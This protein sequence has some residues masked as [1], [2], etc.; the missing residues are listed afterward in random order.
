M[1]HDDKQPGGVLWATVALVV[2][3]VA[4]PLSFGPACWFCARNGN[5]LDIVSA[6]YRPMLGHLYYVYYVDTQSRSLFWDYINFGKPDNVSLWVQQGVDGRL[7]VRSELKS[8][9]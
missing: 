3:L 8:S 7:W 9:R 2:A 5:G 6:V 4:Y 1:R